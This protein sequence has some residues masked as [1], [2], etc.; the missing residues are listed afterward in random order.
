MPGIKADL[1][2][3]W[4]LWELRLAIKRHEVAAETLRKAMNEHLAEAA[5]IRVQLDERMDEKP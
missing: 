1:L 4:R 5:A 3:L 2:P